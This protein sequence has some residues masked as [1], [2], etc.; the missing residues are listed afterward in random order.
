MRIATFAAA[1]VVTAIA[2][3]A[4]ASWCGQAGI[5]CQNFKVGENWHFDQYFVA[6]WDSGNPS[7]IARASSGELRWYIWDRCGW[8]Y[9]CGFTTVSSMKVGN[10]WNYTNYLIGDWNADGNADL[11]V[12]DTAGTMLLYPFRETFYPHP[13]AWLEPESGLW[14]WPNRDPGPIPVA[15]G[16]NYTN[17]FVGDWSGSGIM[18]DVLVRNQA[19]EMFLYP[20]KYKSFTGGGGPIKVGDGWNYTNYFVADWGGDSNSDVLVRNS[21]GDM[22]LYIFANGT[23]PS[24]PV[25]VGD[26]WNFTN[27]FVG[28]WIGDE[29]PDLL[30]RNAAGDMLLYEFRDGTFY[31]TQGPT[32]VGN[33]WNFS[34]YFVAD[35]VGDHRPDMVVRTAS[36]D[37]L[38][39]EFKN[40][41][42]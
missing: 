21:T 39:Y 20:F 13:E 33:G 4:D 24:T 30:V 15:T 38:L 12:R 27:Y 8:A 25:K 23:F 1:L 5:L 11:L 40:G 31:H 29:R 2:S 10:G 19:G 7:M 35:W 17:Y 42:F 3:D 36:G 16:W 14:L 28:D 6:N 26:G 9:D 32:Q 18:R 34:D 22:F 37:M 41:H